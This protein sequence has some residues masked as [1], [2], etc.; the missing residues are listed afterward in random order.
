LRIIIDA[1]ACPREVKSICV[2]VSKKYNLELIMVVDS[3]HELRG[4]FRV[5]QVEKGDDSVD[6]E[7]MKISTKSDIVITQDY[8]LATIILEKTHSVIHPNGFIYNKFNIDTLMFSR[9]MS[10]KI[11]AS[12]GRTRGPKKRKVNNDL[13]FKETLLSILEV[14]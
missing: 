3:A 10:A 4:N 9:H 13:E 14:L 5:I 8:G 2:E 12:G 6:L 7:I 1:D 11:R